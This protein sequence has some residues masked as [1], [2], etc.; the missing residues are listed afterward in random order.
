MDQLEDIVEDAANKVGS[1]ID[2]TKENKDD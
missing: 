1:L 2:K